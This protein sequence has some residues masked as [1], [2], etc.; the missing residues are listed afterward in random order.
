M[1][2]TPYLIFIM[3]LMIWSA[4]SVMIALYNVIRG[5]VLLERAKKEFA[6]IVQGNNTYYKAWSYIFGIAMDI[7]VIIVFYRFMLLVKGISL[8]HT[9]MVANVILMVL[10][11]MIHVIAIFEERNVYLTDLGLIGFMGCFEFSKCRFSWEESQD[12]EKLS[13]TLHIYRKN[14][15]SPFTVTF[16]LRPDVA[17]RI[18][19]RN[20]IR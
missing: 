1:K 4:A 12:P 5:R 3:V 7:A 14:T 16:D 17:H 9:I 2:M 15:K 8:L 11:I 18:T 6:S 19:E 10:L 13:N 20:S